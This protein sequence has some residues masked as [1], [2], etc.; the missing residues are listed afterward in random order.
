LPAAW[1]PSSRALLK[2]EGHG[3]IRRQ[4]TALPVKNPA[5]FA[6]KNLV[7]VGGGDS[8][9]DWALNFAA[10]DG[11]AQGRKRHPAAPPRRLP[12]R[13]R[14]GGQ[15]ARTVRRLRDAVHRRPGH[16]HD[17]RTALTGAKVT[18]ADGITRVVP[19]DMPCWCS[20]A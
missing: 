13:A 9:L 18:G 14:I 17:E 3:E 15:D 10:E 12:G 6:G 5:D 11:P 8:A 19:L 16:R 1:A 7:V 4:P 2:V 20:L